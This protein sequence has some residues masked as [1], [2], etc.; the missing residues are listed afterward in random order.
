[1]WEKLLNAM[2]YASTDCIAYGP[3]LML[4]SDLEM[5][6]RILYV[7]LIAFLDGPGTFICLVQL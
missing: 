6:N 2:R 7:V 4:F 5:F 3:H 1:M